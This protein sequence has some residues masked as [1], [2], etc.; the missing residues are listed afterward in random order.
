MGTICVLVSGARGPPVGAGVRGCA[1]VLVRGGHPGSG[2]LGAV[3]VQGAGGLGRSAAPL[4]RNSG[5]LG[6]SGR[7]AGDASAA[8][9]L[10]APGRI[11]PSLARLPTFISALLQA[12]RGWQIHIRSFL[13]RLRQGQYLQLM[14]II[15]DRT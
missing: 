3:G 2:G 4:P 7:G 10:F 9:L 11:F 15:S 13:A 5:R 14:T 1:S 8:G 12:V 6:W